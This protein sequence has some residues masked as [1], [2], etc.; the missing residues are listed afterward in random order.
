MQELQKDFNTLLLKHHELE[1][2]NTELAKEI[3]QKKH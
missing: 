2:I 1:K 3:E